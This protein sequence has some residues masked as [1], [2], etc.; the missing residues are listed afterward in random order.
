[1]NEQNKWSEETL[2]LKSLQDKAHEILQEMANS[3]QDL[4]ESN[5]IVMNLNNISKELNKMIVNSI[6]KDT[7]NEE[8]N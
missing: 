4:E 7:L 6:T 5:G 3:F 1:M 8:K 2:K